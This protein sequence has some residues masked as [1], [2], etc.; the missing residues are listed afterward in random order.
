MKN[1][2]WTKE[3]KVGLFVILCLAGLAYMT[4]STGKL[5][6][7]KKGY[8]VYVTFKEAAGL[9]QKAPVMLN[10][11][12]IGKVDS[13]N[14]TYENNQTRIKLKLWLEEK[15]KVREGSIV[16]IKMMG[17]MGE[18]YIQITSSDNPNFVKPEEN[19][20]GESYVDLDVLIRNIN[21]MVEEN[22]ADIEQAVDGI[23]ALVKNLN[24]TVA[25]NKDSLTQ[26]IKNFEKT[27]QNF[28]EFSD[29]LR[30][31]PWKLL[32]KTKEKPRE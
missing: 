14:P 29:D 21:G 26:M 7:R 18:K 19:I 25:G 23:N 17:M 24:D 8:F 22:R 3:V 16:S 2:N 9:G 27:S 32:F 31:N 12:E 10:G 30:R 6:I 28:E 4:Y 11:L 1:K 5:D 20:I 15:A 13:I